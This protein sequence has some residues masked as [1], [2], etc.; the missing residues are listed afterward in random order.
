MPE[1][2][3]LRGYI[4]ALIA[5]LAMSNVYI[6]SKAA[7]KEVGLIQFGFYWFGFAILWN[8][9]YALP[10]KK[11]SNLS[12]L[13]PRD[14]SFLFVIGF[15]E[16][17][18]TT[19]FFLAINTIENPTIVSFL[20]NMTPVFVTILGIIFLKKNFNK[21]ELIGFVLTLLGAFIISYQRGGDFSEIFIRGTGLVLLSS[22]IFS[23]AFVLAKK[24]IVTIDAP[25][26]TIN[27]VLFLFIFSAL[28]MFAR[29]VSLS[30]SWKGL[31]NIILGSLLGPF[32]AALS[33]YSAIKY[34]EASRTSII[35]SSKGL[36]V[37]IGSLIYFGIF[38]YTYQI[39]G[40]LLAILGVI[41]VGGGNKIRLRKK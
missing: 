40:G 4:L 11:Y 24:S 21:V 39:I 6:F 18:G 38:P 34:L 20:A 33:Q 23:I 35:Q 5:T 1:N 13:K 7:M 36:F 8:L 19:F 32:L 10:Q 15:M 22:L 12:K 28:L 27:R 26:L 29:D 30:I 16:L 25:I 31:Y 41:F 9:I 14:F 2:S 17:A 37:L 3:K